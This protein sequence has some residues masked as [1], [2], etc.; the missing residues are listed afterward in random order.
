MIPRIGFFLIISLVGVVAALANTYEDELGELLAEAFANHAFV[1]EEEDDELEDFLAN[2]FGE[3]ANDEEVGLAQLLDDLIM[4][5]E[6]QEVRRARF[7]QTRIIRKTLRDIS[8]PFEMDPQC[9]RRLYRLWPVVAMRLVDAL[10]DQLD[11]NKQTKIPNHLQVLTTLRFLAECGFQE[12]VGQDYNHPMCQSRVSYITNRVVNAILLQ[13]NRWIQ[14]PSDRQSRLQTQAEFQGTT[15]LTGILRLVD[16]FLVRMGRP[17]LHEEA[18]YNYR[19]GPSVNVQLVCNARGV[20]LAIRIVPGSNNDMHNWNSS[21]VRELLLALRRNAAIVEDE[22]YH[23]VLGDGGYTPSVV[24]L[25]PI[26]N[27]PVISPEWVYTREHCRT[28]CMVECT[29]GAV[30]GVFMASSRS[31]K[32]YYSPEKDAEIVTASAILHNFKRAHGMGDWEDR[33]VANPDEY[34][35]HVIDENYHA[36]LREL[37]IILEAL[38]R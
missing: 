28:R 26:Q 31:R 32:L 2:V 37:D 21:E 35:E 1:D 12:D 23:Y 30:S 18:Y 19:E 10:N 24:L 33:Q 7:L 11:I 29:I 9:F 13:K 4:D 16:G 25:T 14:F 38:Y 6:A 3:Q 34:V 5:A 27:A 20:I 17:H 8:N 36:G 22:G 15:R